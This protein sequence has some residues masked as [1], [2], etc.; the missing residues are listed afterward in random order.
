MS[1]LLVLLPD[2]PANSAAEF[3][4]ALTPDGRLTTSHGSAP[5]ALLP[6][7]R[8]AGA[9]VIAVVPAR[10]VSWHRVE[11]PPGVGPAS[12]RL[13]GVLELSLIHI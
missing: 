9:E 4:Y 1:S 8:G 5:A 10:A 12:P 13:R 6:P 7:V 3:A 11:L 2:G